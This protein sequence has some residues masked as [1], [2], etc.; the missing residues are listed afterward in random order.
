MSGGSGG[1]QAGV[2]GTEGTPAPGN[3]PGQP[4]LRDR[5]GL[6]SSGH[7]W[8]YA[9]YGFDAGSTGGYLD[10]LWEFN[11][12]TNELGVASRQQTRATC[13]ASEACPATAVYGTLGVPAA[14]DTPGDRSGASSWTDNSG[15]LLALWEQCL[16]T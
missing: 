13:W 14:A 15:N 11:P 16:A 8:L 5:V 6:I 12:S 7:F 9:G 10:D 3:A 2:Y 1:E 4:I